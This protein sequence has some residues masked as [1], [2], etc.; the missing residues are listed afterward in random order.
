MKMKM[1]MQMKN[2]LRP[3]LFS[4][5]IPK[6]PIHAVSKPTVA[7]IRC[8][9]EEFEVISSFGKGSSVYSSSSSVRL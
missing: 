9:A 2:R 1:L 8:E 4:R 7:P 5:K 6:R 3:M